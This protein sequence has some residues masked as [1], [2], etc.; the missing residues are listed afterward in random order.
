MEK[1]KQ[2]L[3]WRNDV[4]NNKGKKVGAGKIAAQMS[5]A[6]V[7]ALLSVAEMTSNKLIIDLSK[8]NYLKTWLQQEFTKICVKCQDEKELVELYNRAKKAGLPCTLITDAGHT[9][10]DGIP[11]KTCVGI[12]PG[13]PVE[14]DKIT[15]G[16]SLLY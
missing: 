12:G 6:S 16:L 2:V 8:D 14:I 15:K 5:H 7:G 3:I 9:E 13:N 11:T 10:F 4:V 1:A